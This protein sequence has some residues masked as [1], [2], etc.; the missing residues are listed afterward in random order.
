MGNRKKNFFEHFK[1]LL[2]FVFE[3]QSNIKIR[4]MRNH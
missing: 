4:L 2:L 3:L 1:Y